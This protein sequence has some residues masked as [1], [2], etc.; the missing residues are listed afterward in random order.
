MTKACARHGLGLYIYAGED[1]PEEEQ[2]AQEQKV[3]AD[4]ANALNEVSESVTIEDLEKVW[5]KWTVLQQN[6]TFKMAVIEKK[7]IINRAS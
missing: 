5:R 1:L 2:K 4:V 6:V 3:T 7:N